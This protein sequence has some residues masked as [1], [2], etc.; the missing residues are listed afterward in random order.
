MQSISEFIG[1]LSKRR[2][3]A[4]V[5]N[6]YRCEAL[7]G[8]LKHYLEV[9]F[10]QSG[11]RVLLVGEAPGYK[12][13]RITGIP[14]SSGKLFETVEHPILSRIKEN[15]TLD[16]I[17]AENTASMV[18]RYL[19]DKSFTPLFWNAFP[20]H[21][22]P[23]GQPNKNRAPSSIEIKQGKG[24]LKALADLYQP[25]LIAGIGRAGTHCAQQA[26]PALDITYIRHP[27]YGGKRD[28]VATMNRIFKLLP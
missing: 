4:T 15:I 17:E 9:M 3:S 13:C 14:F 28:F 16:K 24:Y 6:P 23:K 2:N 18:W 1:K 25:S 11:R 7:A 20:Y 5:F 12:G 19:A 27:S 21:P 10:G 8:N 26:F 22:H